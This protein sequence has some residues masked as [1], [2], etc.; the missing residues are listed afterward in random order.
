[1]VL[2]YEPLSHHHGD[3]INVLMENGEVIWVRPRTAERIVS[4][5]AKSHNPPQAPPGGWPDE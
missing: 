1:M 2:L 5:L 4:E 3:G